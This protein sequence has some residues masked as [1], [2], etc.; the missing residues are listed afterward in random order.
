MEDH[1]NQPLIHLKYSAGSA[2]S[3]VAGCSA[4]VVV[5]VAVAVIAAQAIVVAVV[6]GIA[7]KSS[8]S[9]AAALVANL[10][11][12]H[13]TLRNSDRDCYSSSAKSSTITSPKRCKCCA[14]QACTKEM[15][16]LGGEVGN[17]EW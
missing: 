6:A 7:V 2:Y 1:L 17:D 8:T 16:S 14:Q 10:R 11:G 3:L 4:Q 12:P 13:L 5:F 15:N 9:T